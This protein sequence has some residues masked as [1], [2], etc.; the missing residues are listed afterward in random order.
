MVES[1]SI[2]QCKRRPSGDNKMGVRT[3]A[4]RSYWMSN[5]NHMAALT[6]AIIA[7][8]LPASLAFGYLAG[9]SKVF[10]ASVQG[11]TVNL[12]VSYLTVALPLALTACWHGKISMPAMVFI[13][14]LAL[15]FPFSAKNLLDWLAA[16]GLARGPS[17]LLND[18]GPLVL[19]LALAG[20]VS[21]WISFGLF[22]MMQRR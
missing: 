6:A 21:G 12:L 14:A 10:E 4:M 9:T 20:A 3:D 22:S 8:I 13:G 19:L 11:V 7:G 18:V 5:F 16:G 17:S 1:M 2:L 15:A